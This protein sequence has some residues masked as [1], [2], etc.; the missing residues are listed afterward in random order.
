[1]IDYPAFDPASRKWSANGISRADIELFAVADEPAERDEHDCGR[2]WPFRF[3]TWSQHW[4]NAG[5]AMWVTPFPQAALQF[6]HRENRGPEPLA[7]KIACLV[8]L[9][10]GAARN[11]AEIRLEVRTLMRRIGELRRP[12]AVQSAHPGRLAD[13][14]EEAL[15]RLNESGILPNALN[16]EKAAAVRASGGRWHETWLESEIVFSRPP[17][18][19]PLSSRKQSGRENVR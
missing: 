19:P 18:L 8:S 5:G 1:M 15:L 14:L 6:D 4:L 17:F 3:G 11:S 2:S 12:G 13:R 9:N 16:S 10:W 7:K